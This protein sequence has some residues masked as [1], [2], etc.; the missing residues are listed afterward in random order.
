VPEQSVIDPPQKDHESIH[1][2]AAAFAEATVYSLNNNYLTRLEKA[3]V[4]CIYQMPGG[5][6][7]YVF[8]GHLALV[9]PRSYTT[10][11][12]YAAICNIALA[13]LLWV[14]LSPALAK[15]EFLFI[16]SFFGGNVAS[17]ISIVMAGYLAYKRLWLGAGLGLGCAVGLAAIIEPSTFIY[18]ILSRGMHPKYTIAKK[19]F[20]TRF[21]FEQSLA[22]SNR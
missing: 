18:T 21:P 6:F 8:L 3:L 19:L 9:E 10:A 5:V 13:I 7:C 14:S 20:G 12:L 4:E 16:G 15:Q 1:R 2:Q 22:D 17:L 11:L